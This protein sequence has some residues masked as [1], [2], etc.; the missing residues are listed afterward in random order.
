MSEADRLRQMMEEV[1]AMAV[2][3][4]Q[5]EAITMESTAETVE[6]W[7]SLHHLNLIVALETR[8][9]ILLD[10]LEAAEMTSVRA[11]AEAVLER[12]P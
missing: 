10:P 12:R 9:G 1:R 11:L 5:S 8:Y 2:E 3:V 4:L 7:D 6:E